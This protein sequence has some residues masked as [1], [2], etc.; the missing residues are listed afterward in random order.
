MTAAQPPEEE[1]SET[2]EY[3][4]LKKYHLEIVKTAFAGFIAIAVGFYGTRMTHVDK[5]ASDAADRRKAVVAERMKRYEET[6]P[7]LNDIYSYFEFVGKWKE[8][9]PEDMILRK[10][11]LDRE[12]YGYSVLYEKPFLIA[13]TKFMDLAFKTGTGWGK[14]ANLRTQKLRPL[15][16]GKSE[17]V[18]TEE[19]NRGPIFDAYWEL[20]QEAAH[21]LDTDLDASPAGRT[22]EQIETPTKRTP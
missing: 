21:A 17:I 18:F 12:I 7:L 2:S 1:I 14:D 9:S 15:D 16:L 22:K 11:E 3:L 19:D 6:A 8:F 5:I 13:Y 20:Q 4:E 10:R